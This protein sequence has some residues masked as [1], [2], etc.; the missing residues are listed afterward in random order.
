MGIQHGALCCVAFQNVLTHRLLTFQSHHHHA[1]AL[2]LS[3]ISTF[4]SHNLTTRTCSAWCHAGRCSRS[5]SIAQV[6][7]AASHARTA[8][9]HHRTQVSCF[10][11]LLWNTCYCELFASCCCLVVSRSCVIVT[12]C[13]ACCPTSQATRLAQLPACLFSP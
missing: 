9:T 4:R 13:L 3:Q 12:Y 6:V 11:I 10:H 7:A 8:G 1:H 2:S 5:A